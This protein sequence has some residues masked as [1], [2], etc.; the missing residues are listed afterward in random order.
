MYYVSDNKQSQQTNSH[1]NKQPVTQTNK[2]KLLKP[3][4]KTNKKINK[5]L[6]TSRGKVGM[7]LNV[8]FP[9]YCLLFCGSLVIW[10]CSG[11]GVRCV[12][13]DPSFR[14]S[15]SVRKGKSTQR[16]HFTTFI[17]LLLKI[18]SKILTWN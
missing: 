1:K 10:E 11:S 5:A 9:S 2:E 15:R 3:T 16:T 6:Q 17:K 14:L 13:G 18:S 8:N 7:V 12:M 4:V